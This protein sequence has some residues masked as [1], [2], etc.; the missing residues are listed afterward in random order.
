MPLTRPLSSALKMIATQSSC[1]TLPHLRQ[2]V[3]KLAPL[4][5]AEKS[6]DNVGLLVEAPFPKKIDGV[7]KVFTCIDR[8]SLDARPCPRLS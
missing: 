6:W 8:Q 2:A 3:D 4:S 5:L 1:P 7:R